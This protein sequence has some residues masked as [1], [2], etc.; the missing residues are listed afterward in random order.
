MDKSYFQKA[1]EALDP[2]EIELNEE[3]A[4]LQSQ[5]SI[6]KSRRSILT[7]PLIQET[8]T[9]AISSQAN[10]PKSI[11]EQRKHVLSS[12]YRTTSSITSFAVQDPDP[13]AVNKG[14]LLG[15]RIEAFANKRFTRPY[16]V[17][18]NQPN[19]ENTSLRI[20]RHTIPPAIPLAFLAA[21]FLPQPKNGI[22]MK[23]D[24]GTF[25]R[26]LRGQIQSY[27][28]RLAS[29]GS[30]RKGLRVDEVRKFRDEGDEDVE[31]VMD[32]SAIDAEAKQLRIEWADGGIGRVEIGT[33]GQVVR[34]VVTGVGGR[35]RDRERDIMSG[36]QRV[37][38][39]LE[40][41]SEVERI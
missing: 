23:Q 5:I 1:S 33:T 11:K 20:H 15:L 35:N 38:G 22:E 41:L 25:L 6:L 16:Y 3:I 39:L 27:H 30:L 2:E 31:G 40:R 34:S 26:K 14:K 37:E 13:N 7:F 10:P 17:F 9:Q 21:K 32:V 8:F 4:S 29:I 24:L 19:A 36:Y 28:N 18:L 12:L